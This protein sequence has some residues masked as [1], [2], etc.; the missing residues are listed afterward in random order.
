MYNDWRFN[1]IKSSGVPVQIQDSDL[2]NLFTFTQDDL[3]YSLSCFICKVKKYNGEEYPP[4]TIQMY[5]F[6]N[7]IKWK[8]L[9]HSEF[10]M[11]T[12]IVDMKERHA[13]G[14]GI[15]KSADIISMSHGDKMFS[16]GL[17]GD[18]N[19]IQLLCTVLYDCTL[20]FARR[21]GTK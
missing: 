14:L 9:N 5:L 6:K 21:Y 10:T 4:N 18:E 3:S 16:D 15:R 19:L 20:C 13:L 1:C 11:L 8:L 2:N 17:L 12:N 7:S